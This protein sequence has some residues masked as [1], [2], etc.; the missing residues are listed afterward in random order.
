MSGAEATSSS[1]TEASAT[2]AAGDD[3]VPTRRTRPTRLGRRERVTANAAS[4]ASEG[5]RTRSVSQDVALL[6]T[7]VAPRTV[8]QAQGGYTVLYVPTAIV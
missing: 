1:D 6:T 3:T 2:G 5:A 8:M 7:H 4:A